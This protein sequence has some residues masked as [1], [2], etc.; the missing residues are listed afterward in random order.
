MN[1]SAL[2]LLVIGTSI[3]VIGYSGSQNAICQAVFGGKCSWLPGTEVAI[4]TGT[5]K[6]TPGLGH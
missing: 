1:W 5:G 6:Q 4:N 2:V 3:I